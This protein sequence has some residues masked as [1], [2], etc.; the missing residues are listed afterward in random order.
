M[1]EPVDLEDTAARKRAAL[2]VAKAYGLSWHPAALAVFPVGIALVVGPLLGVKLTALDL[3]YCA[4]TPWV[5][6]PLSIGL[7]T[8]RAPLRHQRLWL[9]TT[10]RG[11]SVMITTHPAEDGTA[12]ANTFAAWP[13]GLGLGLE[14][15][16]QVLDLHRDQ[17]VRLR[18]LAISP[19]LVAK[20]RSFGFV[21]RADRSWWVRMVDGSV[22]P[23][24][25]AERPAQGL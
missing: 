13:R 17:R 23:A 7:F 12:E 22:T 6:L 5:A 9:Y 20:Y 18:C 2:T 24:S 3:L 10:P 11:S 25:G 4:A 8:Y 15:G 16:R 1:I 14:L 21:S 19:G